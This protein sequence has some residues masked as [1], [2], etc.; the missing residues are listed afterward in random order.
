MRKYR[1]E[2]VDIDRQIKDLYAKRRETIAAWIEAEHPV[3][4]GDVIET[5]G[6]SHKGKKMRVAKRSIYDSFSKWS[7]KANG[8][9]L[10]K[11]GTEGLIEG[12]WQ[13]YIK[14]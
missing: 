5:N 7:W 14:P 4:V 12:E 9:I 6:Y 8:P 10:K 11:D 3:K 13:A 1:E 2:V